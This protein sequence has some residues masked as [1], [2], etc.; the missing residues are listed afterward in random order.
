MNNSKNY[1]KKRVLGTNSPTFSSEQKQTGVAECFNQTIADGAYSIL[2][3]RNQ[4]IKIL[5][6]AI[7]YFTYTC[8][9]ICY[10]G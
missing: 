6:E 10:K 5:P 9:R 7:L 4:S 2:N 8:N 1:L 3:V